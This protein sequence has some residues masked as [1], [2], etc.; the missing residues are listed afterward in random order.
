[1]LKLALH[2]HVSTVIAK[3]TFFFDVGQFKQANSLKGLLVVLAHHKKTKKQPKQ[4]DICTTTAHSSESKG[5]LLKPKSDLHV[6]KQ[7]A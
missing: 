4:L 3:I 1:M 6:T 2:L 5:R 7:V